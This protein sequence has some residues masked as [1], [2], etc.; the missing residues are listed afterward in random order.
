M[1]TNSG[2]NLTEIFHAGTFGNHALHHAQHNWA[3][4]AQNDVVRLAKVPTGTKITDMKVMFEAFGAARTL[5]VG[6]EAVDP[7]S[8]IT[9]DP[10]Y[11]TA[12][13]AGTGPT[14]ISAAGS[15]EFAFA[16]YECTEPMYITAT[17]AGA[18]GADAD[19]HALVGSV[20]VGNM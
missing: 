6:Y 8:S 20:Y 16:P 19:T 12:G 7:G 11:F 4:E 10:D 9:A 18:A 17:L 2:D 13:V 5:D 14:D 1:A 3:G 15:I